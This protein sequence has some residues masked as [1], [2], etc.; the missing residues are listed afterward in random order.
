MKLVEFQRDTA[1][2]SKSDASCVSRVH[3]STGTQDAELVSPDE[4]LREISTDSPLHYG[5]FTFYQAGFQQLPGKVELSMLRVTSD[6]GRPLKYLGGA[7]AGLGILFLLCM[8]VLLRQPTRSLGAPS[9]AASD[10]RLEEAG[11][12]RR[13]PPE[14]GGPK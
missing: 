10:G 9:P 3:L 2:D 12:C 6:P 1:P 13:S 7:M 8:R 14:N 4:P 11:A 5:A